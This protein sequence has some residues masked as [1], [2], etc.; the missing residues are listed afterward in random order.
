MKRKNYILGALAILCIFWMGGYGLRCYGKYLDKK[1]VWNEEAKV[2]FE[3]ALWMEVNKRSDISFYSSSSFEG[4]MVTLKQMIP[5]SVSVMTNEG[6]RRYKIDRKKYDKSLIK[7]SRQ[8]VY[9]GALL[10]EYPLSVD[11]VTLHWDSLLCEKR[12]P[13]NAQLRYIHTDLL[14]QNDTTYSATDCRLRFDSLSVS[15]MGFRCE[16]ELTAFVSCPHWLSVL[17]VGEWFLWLLPLGVLGL[18]AVFYAP[19]EKFFR[20]KFVEVKVV[21]KEIHVADV[22][23]DKAKIYQ[24]PDGSLFDSFAGT[25]TKDGFIYTLSPQAALLLRL[26]LRKKNHYL[27]TAEIE[28]EL[29]NGNVS[30]DRIHKAIQ[31]LRGELKKV[32]LD[33]VIKNVNGDYELK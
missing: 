8:R 28:Q 33:L 18:L 13:V 24:L 20:Q 26:F 5:D 3:E 23:I 16:H 1:F 27:S 31:R 14:L 17:N 7:E 2:T 9:L 30:V 25:L 11:T 21:E 12:V 19:V 15:Y 32:S 4:G 29:W 6:F 10:A 22:S